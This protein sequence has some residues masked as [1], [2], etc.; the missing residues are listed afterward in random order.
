VR[1]SVAT[2]SLPDHD[3]DSAASAIAAAGFAGVEWR[4]EPRTG[5][6]TDPVPAHP[7]LVDHAS[8]IPLNAGAAAEATA[9]TRRAG[10]E[11]VGLGAYIELDDDETLETVFAMARAAGAPRVRLQAPRPGRTGLSYSA[12]FTRFVSFFERVQAEAERSGVR[13][14]LEIHHRTICPSAALAH[15]VLERFDP[16]TVGAIYDVGNLVWEGFV[17]HT[18]AL[19]QLGPYLGHVHVKNAA[20]V[21]RSGGGWE[22][23][24]TPLEDGLVDVPGFLALLRDS[25]YDGWVSIEELSLDRSPG[26][27]LRHN[28]AQLRRWG[29]M[30]DAGAR[31]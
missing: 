25:G 7:F 28:A 13:A 27:A 18:L 11:L 3:L 12:L 30:P 19:D 8:S 16:R 26:E 9:L 17:P 6:I 22:Y 1:F 23:I 4:V 24:W 14:L 31:R 15:R 20:A 29:W 10:L 5:S 21:R 2:I